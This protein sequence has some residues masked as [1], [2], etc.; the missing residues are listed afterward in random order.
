LA[1]RCSSLAPTPIPGGTNIQIGAT[2]DVTTANLPTGGAISNAG[3]NLLF[4]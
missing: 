4:D 2:L 1:A 3:G